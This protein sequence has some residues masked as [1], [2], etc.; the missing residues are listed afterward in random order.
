MSTPECAV[1]G[2]HR[3]KRP[4]DNGT[5][6]YKLGQRYRIVFHHKYCSG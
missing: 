4:A 5:M 2:N 1:L 3:A 6:E